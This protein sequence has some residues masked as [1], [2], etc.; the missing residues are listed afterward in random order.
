MV[1]ALIIGGWLPGPQRC[2]LA[3]DEPRPLFV[4]G[5]AGQVSYAPGEALTLHVSTSAPRF[6]VE[7]ARVGAQTE[8]VWAAEAVEGREH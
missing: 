1:L 6:A 4:E 7:I 8:P 3:V 2:A 5:Y